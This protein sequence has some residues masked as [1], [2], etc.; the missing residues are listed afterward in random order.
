M[1]EF[2]LL[3]FFANFLV[4]FWA[5][6]LK[7]THT[8]RPLWGAKDASEYGIFLT[9]IIYYFT[10]VNRQSINLS[11]F[12][13]QFLQ[14]SVSFLWPLQILIS[15]PITILSIP[16]LGVFFVLKHNVET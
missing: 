15:F 9:L 14:L 1:S 16:Q 4:H 10:L 11:L 13:F 8:E 2:W 7:Y 5:L 3:D 6:S 12:S